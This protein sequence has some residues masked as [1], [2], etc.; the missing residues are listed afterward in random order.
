MEADPQLSVDVRGLPEVKELVERMATWIRDAAANEHWRHQS[1]YYDDPI[2][3]CG[4]PYC[5]SAR[6]ALKGE[7]AIWGASSPS[8]GA[9]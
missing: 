5:V 8:G 4:A 3:E 1:L 7:E 2:D 9:S 6:V